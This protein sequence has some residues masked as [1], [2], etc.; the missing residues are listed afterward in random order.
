M[1]KIQRL[2]AVLAAVVALTSSANAFSSAC[3]SIADPTER[4]ACYDKAAN[5]GARSAKPAAV[6]PVWDMASTAK[7]AKAIAKA[8]PPVTS[9]PRSWVEADV[10]FY[11]SFRNIPG[12]APTGLPF[13]GPIFVPSSPG[14]IGL[15]SISTV[16]NPRS[17]PVSF[18]GGANYAWGYWLNPQR[19]TAIEGSAFFGL[20]YA[21]SSAAQAD[22]TTFINTTPD[23]FVGLFDDNTTVSTGGVWEL[24]YGTD[25]NYRM[26]VPHSQY[27]P[28]FP[29]DT[30]FDVLVGWRYIGLDEFTFSSS[31]VLTR[32]YQKALGLPA[33]FSIPVVN[34]HR[35]KF[36]SVWNNFFGPQTG[37]NVEQ[38]WGRYWVESENK[39]GSGCH[40]RANGVLADRLQHNAD[41]VES[42]GRHP[43]KRQQWWAAHYR[44]WPQHP[45]CQSGV[46]GRAKWHP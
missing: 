23:V 20:G 44:K 12:N 36:F 33:P 5:A 21:N 2:L 29:S 25:A 8:S 11:G 46:Y 38:H 24:F 13:L 1:K 9:V 3:S 35:P 22:K 45:R 16:T 30:K 39:G 31:S 14:F 7:P 43:D 34:S 32:T 40:D 41:H 27:F 26:N 37:F 18:G 42:L 28:Y 19:T 17:T 10:G 4:L 6:N 15:F